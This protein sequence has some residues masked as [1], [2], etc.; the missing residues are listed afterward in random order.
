MRNRDAALAAQM[1][2]VLGEEARKAAHRSCG[3]TKIGNA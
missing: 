2:D 3:F 1:Q